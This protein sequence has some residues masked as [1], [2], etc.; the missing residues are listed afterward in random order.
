MKLKLEI[1]PDL[2]ALMQ[3]EIAAGEK[4]VTTAMRAAGTSLK[5]AWRGQ[6]TGAGRGAGLVKRPVDRR[7]A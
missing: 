3:A 4:A 1:S 2:A 7:R 5:S 6:I